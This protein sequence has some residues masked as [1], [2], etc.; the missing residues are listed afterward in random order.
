MK[1]HL[2]PSL[3][4]LCLVSLRAHYP[5][6]KTSSGVCVLPQE[7]HT[8]FCKFWEGLTFFWTELACS[9]LRMLILCP[10]FWLMCDHFLHIF[11]W[12]RRMELAT[13]A[14][15]PLKQAAFTFGKYS[16]VIISQI[17]FL[18]HLKFLPLNFFAIYYKD[19]THEEVGDRK[20][21]RRECVAFTSRGLDLTWLDLGGQSVGKCRQGRLRQCIHLLWENIAK[22]TTDPG[23]DYFDQ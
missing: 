19:F 3:C 10:A 13:R 6:H 12:Q 8:L 18:L 20:K 1:S 9:L 14:Q 21:E 22:G 11:F 15:L 23:V 16:S 7:C 2:T 4:V 5:D 17:E